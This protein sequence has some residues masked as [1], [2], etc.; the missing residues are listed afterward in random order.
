MRPPEREYRI[1][2][3][4]LGRITNAD[5]AALALARPRLR[6]GLA[7]LFMAVVAEI[8]A[9][10]LA[11]QPALGIVAASIA[12]ATSLALSI[13]RTTSRTRCRRRSARAR[14]G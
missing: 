2:D 5:H 12:V 6:L 10:M 9:T 14:S 11:G 1:L 7:L 13:G 3:K 8:G 4:D